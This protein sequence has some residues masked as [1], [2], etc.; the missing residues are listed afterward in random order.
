MAVAT[1]PNEV[2]QVQVA[3]LRH[4]VGEQGV[5][6]DVERHAQENV[7]AALVKLAAQAAFATRGC[8]GGDVKLEKCVAGHERHLVEFGHVPGADDDAAAVGVGFERVDDLLD[9][10][11]MAAAGLGPTAP[12]HAIHRPQVAVGTG[13]F[14]PNRAAALLQPLH[15]AV[16]T[17]EPQQLDD[18]GLHEHL[19]GGDQR[20]TLVEVEAHL[21]AED[22]ARAG[23]GAIAFFHAVLKHMAHE[24]FVLL[25]Y[26]A[27]CGVHGSQFIVLEGAAPG[28]G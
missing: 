9:L 23:A 7:G 20:K 6:G 11:H 18:D 22:A 24:V 10:V 21:V 17:Q 2:A 27:G 28:R 3:L 14:V 19:F 13:P 25:A 8:G 1:G 12:L 4:H 16:A 26:G 5:A 15:V